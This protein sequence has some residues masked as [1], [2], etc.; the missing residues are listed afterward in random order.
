M[1]DRSFGICAPS[2][3]GIDADRSTLIASRPVLGDTA[4]ERRANFL[5]LAVSGLLY[6]AGLCEGDDAVADVRES[7]LLAASIYAQHRHGISMPH[8]HPFRSPRPKSR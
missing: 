3:L 8:L 7:L 1:S 5:G 6:L 2:L 4:Q